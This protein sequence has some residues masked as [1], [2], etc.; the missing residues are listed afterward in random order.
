M[1]STR[2]IAIWLA[3]IASDKIGPEAVLLGGLAALTLADLTPALLPG[4]VGVLVGVGL[5]G[6]YMGLSQGLLSAL[7]ADGAPENLRGTAFGLFNLLTGPR[8]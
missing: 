7:V 2:T 6:F 5:W 1:S 3:G 8:S 4:L